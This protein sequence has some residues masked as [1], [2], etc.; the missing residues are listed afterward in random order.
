MKNT[1]LILGIVALFLAS[2][3]KSAKETTINGQVRT[4][5]TEDPIK[6]PPVKVQLLEKHPPAGSFGAGSYYTTLTETYTDQDGYYTLSHKLYEDN[7]YYIAVDPET[8][9]RSKGYYKPTPGTKDLPERRVTRIGGTSTINYYLTAVGWVEFHFINTRSNS[10]F[11]YSVGGG[12]YEQFFNP[13]YEIVR[14]WDFGG[15]L[16]HTIYMGKTKN[17]VDSVWNEVI[18]VPA[19]DTLI[20][21]VEY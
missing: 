12:G 3:T 1:I 14:T 4:Y 6:H 5:G 20:Y 17:G 8:V 19:F 15:N 13:P 2:C 16:E 11:S 7:D 18:Y 10:R 21:E 9:T